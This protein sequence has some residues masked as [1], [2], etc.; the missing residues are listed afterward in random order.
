[1][2]WRCVDTYAF[3][4]R[5]EV[6]HVITR[7]GFLFLPFKGR[8]EVGMGFYSRAIKPIPLLTSPLKGGEFRPHCATVIS[9]AYSEAL[10]QP[11]HAPPARS[12]FS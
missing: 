8:T 11:P 12:G 10:H 2:E 1:M 4:G 3:K 5:T 7:S 6:G 9:A